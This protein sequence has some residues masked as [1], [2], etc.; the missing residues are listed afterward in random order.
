[1]SRREVHRHPAKTKVSPQPAL[2]IL[3]A[4]L[5]WC[6]RYPFRFLLR[7][8]PLEQPIK[9]RLTGIPIVCGNCVGHEEGSTAVFTE[10]TRDRCC[11]DCGGKSFVNAGWFATQVA[12]ARAVDEAIGEGRFIGREEWNAITRLVGYARALVQAPAKE[13]GRRL[14]GLAQ[15]LAELDRLEEPE[16]E[17]VR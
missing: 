6:E 11:A 16:R 10:M 4:V 17:Y 9:H 1:M 7:D 8:S 2:T 13:Q 14:Y 5:L 12:I 3:E 15:A